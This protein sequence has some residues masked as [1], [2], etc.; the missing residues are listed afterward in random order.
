MGSGAQQST[1]RCKQQEPTGTSRSSYNAFV[2][3]SNL[4]HASELPT[5]SDPPPLLMVPLLTWSPPAEKATA[6]TGAAASRVCTDRLLRMSHSCTTTAQQQHNIPTGQ[7]ARQRQVWA[8]LLGEAVSL[9]PGPSTHCRSCPTGLLPGEEPTPGEEH[10][11]PAGSSRLHQP[12]AANP[13]I[14]AVNPDS[15]GRAAAAAAI[16]TLIL[17]SSPPDTNSAG[18]RCRGLMLLTMEMCSDSRLICM[19]ASASQQRTDLSAD[20]VT[21]CS[22]FGNHWTCSSRRREVHTVSESNSTQHGRPPL[23]CLPCVCCVL[24]VPV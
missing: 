17:A 2:Y 22:P 20:E 5:T 12:Y 11:A 1:I 10:A 16:L 23:Q 8:L 18:P 6:Q 4:Q 3:L 24:S 9:P 21:S 13:E 14:P 15:T 19:P 7:Q